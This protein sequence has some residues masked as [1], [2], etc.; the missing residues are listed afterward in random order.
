[1]KWSLERTAKLLK[2]AC[3]DNAADRYPTATAMLDDLEACAELS[4]GSLFDELLED[5]SPPAG[6]A[7]LLIDLGYAFVDRLPWILGAIVVLY[8]IYKFV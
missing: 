2:R 1:M 4:T 7:P 3:A 5:P 6:S 8:L